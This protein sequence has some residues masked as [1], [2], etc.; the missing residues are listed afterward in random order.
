MWEPPF[1]HGTSLT[2]FNWDGEKFDVQLLGDTAH[3]E[4]SSLPFFK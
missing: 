1:I 4:K 3:L 2:V